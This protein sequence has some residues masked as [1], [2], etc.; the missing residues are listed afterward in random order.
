MRK[1]L[2]SRAGFTLVELMVVLAVIALLI[3]IVAPHYVGR[4]ARAEE[5]VLRENLTLMRDALDRHY[6][7]A[8]RYPGSL[9]ELVKKRY[10]RS[11]PS[12]PMTQ[13]NTTWVV[14][15]PDDPKKGAVFDVRSGAKGTG[16]NGKPYEQW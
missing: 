14:I 10:L 3:S 16:A 1:S 13:S 2:K 6:A 12:D 7:D 9:D 8:G 11:I 5:A 15:G 4:I